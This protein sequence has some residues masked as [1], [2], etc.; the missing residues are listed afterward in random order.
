MSSY[1]LGS[2]LVEASLALALEA[3]CSRPPSSESSSSATGLVSAS[4]SSLRR[5]AFQPPA[6]WDSGASCSAGDSWAVATPLLSAPLEPR[7]FLPLPEKN[8]EAPV[9]L[10]KALRMLR[11]RFRFAGADE[12]ELSVARCAS[13]SSARGTTLESSSPMSRLRSEAIVLIEF[14]LENCGERE[15]RLVSCCRSAAAGFSAKNALRRPGAVVL[16][17]AAAR[18]Q[19]QRTR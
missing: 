15:K 11:R 16:Q 8:P 1:L 18:D 9:A 10:E 3:M 5:S 2:L 6:A 12:V 7:F 14:G 13:G 17:S 19:R 4:S